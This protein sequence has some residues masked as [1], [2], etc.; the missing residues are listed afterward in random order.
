MIT[1]AIDCDISVNIVEI[2]RVMENP[3][4]KSI[5]ALLNAKTNELTAST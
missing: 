1:L 5:H 2:R 3:S 4:L